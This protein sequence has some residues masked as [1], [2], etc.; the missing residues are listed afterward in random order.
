MGARIPIATPEIG[1][2]ELR[3]VTEA[4]RS[5]WV[6]SKGPF[7]EEFEN[8]F[9]SYVGTKYGVATSSGTTALHLALVALQIGKGDRVLVPSLTFVAAANAITYTGAEPVFIDSDPGYWCIDPSKIEEKIDKRT[10]AI[11]AVHLYGHPCDMDKIIAIAKTH[12]LNIIEDCAEA[13]GAEYKGKKVG[14]FGIISC[15]SF[16]GNKIITTGEGGMCLTDSEESKNKMRILRDHGM[17]PDRKYWHEIIGFNYRM[18][19]LQAALGVA[20]MRRLDSLIN[21]KRTIA[22]MYKKLFQGV[23]DVTPAPEMSW[24]RSV[25]WLYSILVKRHARSK[26]IEHLASK[27]IETRPFFYPQHILPPYRHGQCLP[28][29]EELSARGLNMPSGTR[30]SEEEICQIVESLEE[31]L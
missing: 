7:I 19:N 26:V 24:A 28:V 14:S 11:L 31:A 20:Q 17:S 3:N 13:H 1:E 21:K 22:S 6:S 2:E 16:Y 30:L 25:Y 15:F 5:G 10:R 23:H 12:N 29:A 18:T 9:S 27:G 4:V 8:S